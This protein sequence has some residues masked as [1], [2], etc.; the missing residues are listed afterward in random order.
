[1]DIWM[2]VVGGAV[3]FIIIVCGC[4]WYMR[5]STQ[6]EWS[7]YTIQ[8]RDYVEQKQR[9]SGVMGISR[10]LEIDGLLREFIIERPGA[11]PFAGDITRKLLKSF[12]LQQGLTDYS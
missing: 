9:L 3:L 7:K 6:D 8:F 2:M 12:K 4:I 1:M 11:S 10:D 5:R